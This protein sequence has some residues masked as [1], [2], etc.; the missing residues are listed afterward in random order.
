MNFKNPGRDAVVG[1]VAV[2]GGLELSLRLAGFQY[3]HYPVSM[4]YVATV[5]AVGTEQT[6]HRRHFRI[7]YTIDH[8]LLW[9]P[10]PRAGVTNS[11][12][13]LGPEWSA[14]KTK[15]RLIA[16]GDSCTVAGETPYPARLA[17]RLR[18]WE[19][20]NAGVGSWSSYQG[21]QLLKKRLLAYKP[22]VVTIY[23][24]WNDHWL[25]WAAPD[26]ELAGQ[27][28]KQWRVLRLVEKSRLL[29]ALLRAADAL[30]GKDARP[31]A[32]RF[33]VSI[34]DYEANL[35]RMVELVHSAGGRAVLITAPSSLTPTH[36]TTRILCEQTRNFLKP[37]RIS[38]VHDSYNDAVRRVAKETGAAL[39]DLAAS[40]SGRPENFTDGIHL[41]PAGHAAAAEEIS[42]LLR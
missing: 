8:D 11:Q 24:G 13:F 28:D 29:Q 30:R 2:L 21:L 36:P 14:E 4:R 22:E 42:A 37:E 34:G 20:W 3:A 27:L 25:A 18:G 19:V 16:L 41:S 23:F 35:R 5:A 38:E 40:L 33:R 1:T 26:K 15:P 7:D 39:A 6:L 9:R 31:T 10:L 12:G 32:E 17:E